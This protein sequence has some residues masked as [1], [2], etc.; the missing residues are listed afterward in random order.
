MP[1]ADFFSILLEEIH[2]PGVFASERE[3][4]PGTVS[5]LLTSKRPSTYWLLAPHR[6]RRRGNQSW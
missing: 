5:D 3:L 2:G 1:L 6:G 4:V